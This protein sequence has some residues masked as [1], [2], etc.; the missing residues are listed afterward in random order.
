MSFPSV[1]TVLF[2]IS[3]V[4]PIILFIFGEL[5]IDLFM[6][7]LKLSLKVLIGEGLLKG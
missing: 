4:T 3:L 5:V 7:I 6:I 2:F 1:S